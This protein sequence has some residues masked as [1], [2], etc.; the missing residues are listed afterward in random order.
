MRKLTKRVLTV[1]V[2]AALAATV[3]SGVIA[4]TPKKG[5]IL[6]FV[7][8]SKIPSLDLHAETTF[9]VIHPIRP[10]YSLL[11]RVNPDNPQSATDLLC[12]IC[13]GKVELQGDAGSGGKTYT[14]NIRKNVEFHDGTKLTAHDVV[15]SFNKIIFPPAGV[16]SSRKAF[17]AMVKSVTASDDF[18]VVFQLNYPSGAFVGAIAMPFNGIYAKKDIERKDPTGKDPLYGFKWHQQNVNGTGAFQF[19]QRQP[20]AFVEGKRYD[21]YHHAGKPYLDG[22]K[23][24]IAP[25]MSK[26][27]QA[28]R[29]DRAS[30]EFRGFPPKQRDSLVDALGDGI[31]VQTSDWNCGLLY[32]LNEEDSHF[33]D[34]RVRRALNLAVDRWKAQKS[35]SQI[36]IVK[37]AA[38]IVFP[39]HPLAATQQELMQ[40]DG[41]WKDID[42]SRKMSKQLLKEAGVENLTFTLNNRASD[43]PYR[44]IGTWLIGEWK[45]IGLSVK[46]NVVPTPQWFQAMRS[47]SFE[48]STDANCQS[49]VN[50][51]IDSAKYLPGAVNNRS[52]F[53]DAQ[54]LSMHDAMNKSAD[55]AEQRKIMRQYEARV[56][57]NGHAGL[58]LWWN[59]INPH[60]SYVKGWKIAPSH[61]LNQ[62][63]DQVWLDK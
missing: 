17:F 6:T 30:I 9:G 12:D 19:V 7:V 14:Y 18:T 13:E 31:T 51:L 2:G 5:G 48:A 63:L 39:G 3:S 22:Y 21:K 26:R 58:T 50:P 15:A 46:Q 35:L 11:I 25:Q 41:F 42:A 10:L 57:N 38:G 20:G 60:R 24:I 43:Q 59:K 27:V 33:K 8:G 52:R 34:L 32:T 54:L 49:V 1:A 4:A 29:G 37:T 45:K 40:L 47:G 53:K 62:H 16:R 36:A 55:P 23:S 56:L 28:I 44:Y 61:Y